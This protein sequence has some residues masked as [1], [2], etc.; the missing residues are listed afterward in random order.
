MAEESLASLEAV[1]MKNLSALHQ[2]QQDGA[3]IWA[4][5]LYDNYIRQISIKLS[6]QSNRI[7][8]LKH[9][10]SANRKELIEAMK[11]RK[12]LDRLKE[13]KWEAYKKTVERKEQ[14]FLGETAIN[15]FHR[16]NYSS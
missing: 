3:G 7:K 5:V 11:R 13:K 12:T 14:I 10:L 9:E 2:K 15:G 6:N 16:T 1:K 8:E 4:V